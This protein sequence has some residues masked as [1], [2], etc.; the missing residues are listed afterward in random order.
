MQQMFCLE[1]F[2]RLSRKNETMLNNVENIYNQSEGWITGIKLIQLAQ[3]RDSFQPKILVKNY[4]FEEILAKQK[5]HVM[6]KL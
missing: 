2:K 1:I 5:K 4:L 3:N 6:Y